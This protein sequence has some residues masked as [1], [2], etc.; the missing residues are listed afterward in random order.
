MPSS[1]L[2]RGTNEK[3]EEMRDKVSKEQRK[4][5]K[6]VM[7]DK[8][9]RTA[10]QLAESRRKAPRSNHEDNEEDVQIWKK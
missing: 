10:I 5:N 8:A 1:T 3:D 9:R 6:Q 4:I 2:G 7:K